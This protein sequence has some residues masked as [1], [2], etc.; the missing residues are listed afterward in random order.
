MVTHNDQ[1]FEIWFSEGGET[2]YPTY[3]LI[4]IPNEKESGYVVIDP[5]EKYRV[6]HKEQS[7]EALRIWLHEDEYS[8]PCGR[9]FPDDGW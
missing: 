8:L 4:V 2:I 1:W 3:L 5:Q 6:V 7:Y 9:E